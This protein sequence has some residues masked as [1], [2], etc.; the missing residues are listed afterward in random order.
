MYQKDK[1][2]EDFYSNVEESL[3]EKFDSTTVLNDPS[4]KIT[5]LINEDVEMKDESKVEAPEG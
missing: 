5:H 2:S 1:Y 3:V 4:K